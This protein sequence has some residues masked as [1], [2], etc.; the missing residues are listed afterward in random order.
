[1][2]KDQ[3]LLQEAYCKI[4]ESSVEPL[5]FG[6]EE[7]KSAW[8]KWLHKHNYKVN[9]DGSLSMEG[10]IDLKRKGLVT[11]LPFNFLEVKGSF[12]CSRNRLI[13]LEGCPRS[14]GNSFYCQNNK[15]TSL[16]GAPKHVGGYFSCADNQLLT[17]QGAPRYVGGNFICGDNKLI[18]LKGSPQHV[19]GLFL[20]TRNYITSLQGAPK[21]VGIFVSDTFSDQDYKDYIRKQELDK[22]ADKELSK[23]FSQQDLKALE[24]F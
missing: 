18:S 9:D 13:S 24:D 7:D 3:Q 19:G 8:F 17:L 2:N 5:Y 15:L 10:D 1:V 20:C 21:K 22:R 11:R 6:L 23:D 12:D 14:V 16:K 4:Y